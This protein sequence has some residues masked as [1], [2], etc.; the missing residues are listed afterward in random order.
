MSDT[1][2]EKESVM[3]LSDSKIN[4]IS[5]IINRG[6][7]HFLNY[8]EKL[9]NRIDEIEPEIHSLVDEPDRRSRLKREAFT[10]LERYPDKDS[11]PPLFGIPVG[12]KDIFTVD[13]FDTKCGSQLPSELFAG[14]EAHCVSALRQAGVLIIGKTETTD[15]RISMYDPKT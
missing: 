10:L 1:V 3:V 8:V 13:G 14:P 12:I 11:R 15:D 7:S 4:N 6:Q 2:T 5:K 9:C